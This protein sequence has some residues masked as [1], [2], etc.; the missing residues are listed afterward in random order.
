MKKLLSVILTICLLLTIMPLGIFNLTASA[1]TEYTEGYYTYT[2]SNGE[3]TIT[4]AD[5]SISG[6]VTIPSTLGG[7][8]VTSIG[9]YTFESCADI[10]SIAMPNSVTSIG[11]HVFF[12]CSKL[13]SITLSDR[14]MSIG[15]YAFNGCSKIKSLTIPNSVISIGDGAFLGCSKLENVTIPDGVTRI[16][17]STF[18]YCRSITSITIP[19]GVKSIGAC[20]FKKCSSLISITIPNSVTSIGDFAF[21]SCESLTGITIP[22]SVTSIA[23][24]T[25][26]FCDFTS[27]TIPDGVTSIGDSAF[28]YC[29]E[30]TSITIPDSVTSIGEEAFSECTNILMVYYGGT[31]KEWD[32]INIASGNDIF[33]TVGFYYKGLPVAIVTSTNDVSPSQTVTL[34]LSDNEG[35]AGYYWGTDS[36]YSNNSY[37]STDKTSVTKS[38]YTEGTYY[39]TAEDTSG[40]LSDTVSVTFY[41][42]ILNSKGGSVSPDYVLT[43]NSNSFTLPTPTKA[44]YDFLGW[45]EDEKS[46]SYVEVV[47]PTNNKTYY[48][49][50]KDALKPCAT[51]SSTNN[52]SWYQT[53]TLNLSDNEGTAGFY[54]GTSNNYLENKYFSTVHSVIE[55]TIV[56]SGTYYLTAKDKSGNISETVSVTFFKTTFDANG[57]E[58]AV[59][60]VLTMLG[61]SFTMP[62]AERGKYVFDGWALSEGEDGILEITP[63]ADNTYFAKWNLP[64][65]ATPENVA[66]TLYGYDDVILSWDA[67]EGATGYAVY[68]KKSSASTYTKK[69]NTTAT[70]CKFANLSDS[71]NYD[72]KVVAYLDSNDADTYSDEA[73][74]TLKTS[75]PFGKVSTFTA[76]LYG[77]DDVEL[78]WGAVAGATGYKIYYKK[79]SAKSYTYKTTTNALTYSIANLTDNCKYNF[80]IVPVANYTLS[81]TTG[82]AKAITYSTTKDLAAP[83]TLKASLYGY[84]D[85]KLTWSAVSGASRYKIYYKQSSADTYKY[86]TYTT[87]TTYNFANLYDGVSY[88]FK[89]VPCS[90]VNGTHFEADSFK[91][92]TISSTINLTAPETLTAE[93][94]GYDDVKLNWSEVENAVA[95][96]VYYKKSTSKSYVYWKTT[97]EPTSKIWNLSDGIKYD[98]KVVPCTYVNGDYFADD[99]AKTASVYTLKKI[100][101]PTVKKHKAGKVR[102]AWTNIQGESGYEISRSLGKTGTYIVSDYETTGGNARI[103]SAAKGK[104]YYYKIRAY[105]IVDGNKIYG[106]WSSVKAYKLK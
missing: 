15:N 22:D 4:S 82:T 35:I 23:E 48:A 94:Y 39:L 58:V 2:V 27:I 97:T 59:N 17:E 20:A 95:Y 67:V 24:G 40:N 92:V 63:E 7:Y 36:N 102:I 72:F 45:A 70:S 14:L 54:W 60:S 71:T 57:G 8:P 101:T 51:I 33:S 64:E 80:K 12:G 84:D 90:Y 86:K 106:P 96:K 77:H 44:G 83:K 26:E 98:F 6:D 11:K 99:S 34:D 9:N 43:M 46:E 10:T 47:T 21:Y 56:N 89:I 78:N 88:D 42:T 38:I 66:A 85:A 31:K 69:G 81:T 52:V 30:L 100:S 1:E 18:E 19:N 37:T 104:T 13:T 93:L 32:K 49:I 68:Y 105:K 41:K 16:G 55:F 50:W 76:T 65:I 25:F 79:A 53:A 5:T 3:A 29:N 103:V 74:V 62:I 73:V 87:K 61:N 91:T 75:C 28:Y